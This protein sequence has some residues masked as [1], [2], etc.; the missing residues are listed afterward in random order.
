M[1]C[2]SKFSLSSMSVVRRLLGWLDLGFWI[3]V[4][5]SFGTDMFY[6]CN[7]AAVYTLVRSDVGSNS[8]PCPSPHTKLLMCSAA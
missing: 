8:K 2:G 6:D 1:P 7:F 5:E 4:I 3:L